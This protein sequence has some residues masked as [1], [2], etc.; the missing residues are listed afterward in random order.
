MDYK[1][2]L[3]YYLECVEFDSAESYVFNT[4]QRHKTY[5]F[6]KESNP[7]Y[8]K[9][10]IPSGKKV[11]INLPGP[12]I[13]ELLIQKRKI[14]LFYGW[15]VVVV[16]RFEKGRSNQN[17]QIPLFYLPLDHKDLGG[18]GYEVS[19]ADNIPRVNSAA[20]EKLVENR[21]ELSDLTKRLIADSDGDDVTIAESWQ[22]FVEVFSKQKEIQLLDTS[23]YISSKEQR[24]YDNEMIFIGEASK[25]VSGLKKELEYL[26][27]YHVSGVES[28]AFGKLLR[29][30]ELI[31]DMP[32]DVIEISPL[33]HSQREAVRNAFK[34]NWSVIYGPPGTGKSQVVANI[35]A[36]A[37]FRNES[38]LFTSKNNKAVDVV[39]QK[40]SRLFSAPFVFRVGNSQ[41]GT[42]H[43]SYYIETLLK[44][45]SSSQAAMTSGF[46][47]IQ[48]NYNAIR[49]EFLNELNSIKDLCE[50]RNISSNATEIYEES[51]ERY[52]EE[53]RDS[54]LSLKP[55]Q[56]SELQDLEN[57]ITKL[58]GELNSFF[59]KI[60]LQ[61]VR[62]RTLSELNAQ[63]SELISM[64]GDI[65]KSEKLYDYQIDKMKKI[66]EDHK[67]LQ[68]LLVTRE[69]AE[70][71]A[72]KLNK[73]DYL[74][75]VENYERAHKKFIDAT[76]IFL[77]RM[78]M[79]RAIEFPT[80]SKENIE[81]YLNTVRQL[82]SN[83]SNFKT[84]KSL[85]E[86]I[87]PSL[88]KCAPLWAVSNLSV[89]KEF[90]LIPSVFD[91]V[92]IDEASQSDIASAVPLLIRAKRVVIIGDKNQLRH[93]T[94][95]GKGL[96]HKLQIRNQ[97]D[98]G[99]LASFAYS[100][101]SLLD[102]VQTKVQKSKVLLDEHYRSHN[103]IIDFSNKTWYGG[104]LDI[105]TN[106]DFLHIKPLNINP[107]EWIDEVSTCMRGPFDVSAVNKGEILKIVSL[108]NELDAMYQ[109]NIPEVGIITPFAAQKQL[110]K[111]TL[112]ST[113]DD[114]IFKKFNIVFDTV[115]G[116]Q[117]DEKDIILFSTVVSS[118]YVPQETDGAKIDFRPGLL[119]FLDDTD[120]LFNV[121]ITRAKSAFWI[122]GDK[123]FFD[124]VGPKRFKEFLN[125]I[126]E[127]Q[128]INVE[129]SV[130][131][132]ESPAE[133]DLLNAM[134]REGIIP[135]AQVRVGPYR[136]DF[137]LIL[138]DGRKI[139]IETDGKFWHTDLS[140]KK[141][142]R[143][144]IRDKYLIDRGYKVLRFWGTEIYHDL[145]KC[146]ERIKKEMSA[147]N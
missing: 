143:D 89:H 107:V 27:K 100:S 118:Q 125:Y 95:I 11:S 55:I 77:G 84:L 59:K 123:T 41:G 30:E 133:R 108:I 15:P 122:V 21:D 65:Y 97:V 96:D 18:Q 2:L 5:F 91:L 7:D 130:G 39:C 52:G 1:N 12:I 126:S 85:Q 31:V 79:Q 51:L 74:A 142:E 29:G 14:Q 24:Y 17:N 109:D 82:E 46:K 49:K 93:I 32:I 73:I 54:I 66:L 6:I 33:N 37:F 44:M 94:R 22:R 43:S 147:A 26:I 34:S 116:F 13:Q 86:D 10:A 119:N 16:Q 36:N 99:D 23:K 135:Q 98:T 141:L 127:E 114:R 102:C 20:F 45:A 124:S 146:I 104:S 134:A 121:A 9:D 62:K 80:A 8:E 112:I 70:Y 4:D 61:L 131:L 58:E 48:S 101:N 136:L 92:V 3:K 53:M 145:D 42:V 138:D 78:R 132:S 129:D 103:A 50:K 56:G 144:V 111:E 40:F 88:L 115:H 72:G 38:V 76:L 139:A 28:S 140:G 71:A 83:S 63:I 90:P 105:R 25:Y 75:I 64:F 68:A 87:F 117:G 110:I 69:E 19:L 106:F 47:L 137:L 57:S 120:Y 35:L 67:G 81:K 113:L 60:Y 128:S